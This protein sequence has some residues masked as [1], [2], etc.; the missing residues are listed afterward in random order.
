MTDPPQPF[1]PT[2]TES[3]YRGTTLWERVVSVVTLAVAVSLGFSFF[4]FCFGA[5]G[6]AR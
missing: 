2:D 3:G 1:G 4:G 6:P 5:M